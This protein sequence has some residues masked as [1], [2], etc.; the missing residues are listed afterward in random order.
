MR[1]TLRARILCKGILR[2]YHVDVFEGYKA[3]LTL[4]CKKKP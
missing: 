2:Y 1:E 4:Y 3:D